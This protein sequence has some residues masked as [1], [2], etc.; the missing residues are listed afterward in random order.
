MGRQRRGHPDLRRAARG[1]TKQVHSYGVRPARC[2]SDP[3][4]AGQT[5]SVRVRP[6]CERSRRAL[7]VTMPKAV[8]SGRN[9]RLSRPAPRRLGGAPMNSTAAIDNLG[10]PPLAGVCSYA[11]AA[12]P[13]LGVERRRSSSSAATTSCGASTRSA[14]AHLAARP[15]GRSSARS[16]CTSGSMPSTAAVYARAS[17]RCASLRSASTTCRT[18]G[19]EAA[20][21]ELLRASGSAELVTGIYRVVRP[22]LVRRSR[23]HLDA[24]NPLFDHPTHRLLRGIEREQEE[25][26]SGGGRLGGADRRAAG[27]GARGRVRRAPR[28]LPGRRGGVAGDAAPET[29]ELPPARWDG[30]TMRWTRRRDATPAS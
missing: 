19:C 6:R 8:R 14:A 2:G 21:E 29:A 20:L 27:R 26:I 3:L 10:I 17:P 16:A 12:L 23:A 5:R 4:G 28:A 30:P 15:N 11:R 25:M 18:S 9:E 1:H 22:A 13:G 7:L 24:M